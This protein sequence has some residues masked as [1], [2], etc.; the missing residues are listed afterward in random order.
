MPPGSSSDKNGCLGIAIE[1][2]PPAHHNDAAEVPQGA[3]GPLG[4]RTR[5]KIALNFLRSKPALHCRGRMKEA[6]DWTVGAMSVS[7]ILLTTMMHEAVH[8]MTC[9]VLGGSIQ[10]FSVAHVRC[11]VP[12]LMAYKTV[13][14]SATF[15]NL[16]VAALLCGWLRSG[17]FHDDRRRFF[18]WLLFNF[19]LL[20]GAGYL[21][22]SGITGAGDWIVVLRGWEPR[23]AYQLGLVLFGAVLLLAGVA[24]SL[25]EFGRLVPSEAPKP[26]G[27]A[28]RI[29]LV[30]YVSA[31]A[32]MFV[33]GCTHPNGPFAFPAVV[34]L[35][36]AIGGLSPLL[37]MMQWFRADVFVPRGETPLAIGPSRIAFA[38]AVGLLAF[39]S[40]VNYVGRA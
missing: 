6:N 36:A 18:V 24:W 30:C 10:S 21:F 15:A 33:V 9:W 29:S 39:A 32:A 20:L 22:A 17:R 26:I 13:A 5:R 35:I 1:D 11:E 4:A 16:I 38:A 12:T 14:A 3:D 28:Q 37:W 7:A 34:G 25:S 19:N 31:S 40:I 27:I 2:A 8:A 23:W